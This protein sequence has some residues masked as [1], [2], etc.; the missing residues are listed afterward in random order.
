MLLIK[1]DKV[2]VTLLINHYTSEVPYSSA[3]K[4]IFIII[5]II[6]II[7]IIKISLHLCSNQHYLHNHYHLY[8]YPAFI[9]NV[10]IFYILSLSS[11]SLSSLLLS[12]SKLTHLSQIQSL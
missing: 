5:I 4:D 12:S 2:F 11:L 10:T 7:I 9:N 6:V 3:M 8:F 1:K